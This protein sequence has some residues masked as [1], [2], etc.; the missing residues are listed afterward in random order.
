MKQSRSNPFAQAT[1]FNGSTQAPRNDY[2][3]EISEDPTFQEISQPKPTFNSQNTGFGNRKRN[4][5]E[6]QQNFSAPED[7]SDFNPPNF[8]SHTAPAN[9]F[10]NS[11]W[12]TGGARAQPFPSAPTS[13][14]N[15]FQGHNYNAMGNNKAEQNMGGYI[16]EPPLLEG[17]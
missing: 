8:Q 11:G 4:P 17:K 14:P 6:N 9:Q 3:D 16:D 2:N 15:D 12:N 13:S 5:F 10:G 7:Y 1:A